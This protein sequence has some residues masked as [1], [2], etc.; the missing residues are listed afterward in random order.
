ML[1]TIRGWRRKL[2]LEA[3]TLVGIA[4]LGGLLWI[5]VALAED[6]LE[7]E[8]DGFDTAIIKGL[9]AADDLATP[10][11]PGWLQDA[12]SDITSLGS[13]TLIT[14]VTVIAVAYLAAANRWRLAALTGISITLGA[15]VE[16]LLKFGFGRPRPDI[17]PHLV[18]VHTLSF[19]SGHAMLSAMTYLTVGAVVASAQSRPR[20]RI[21]VFT[22]SLLLTLLIGASRVY[23]GVH[24]PSD[25]LA[26]WAAGAAW[27]LLFWF[28]ARRIR[29]G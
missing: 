20:L 5:F 3:S 22:T 24:W 27:A 6:V 8:Q 21:F 14:I 19:P 9:R 10:L 26:G 17:V 12:F 13:P 1:E 11:G 25:V 28:I 15:V 2:P 4:V 7:Q 23:L 16:K 18:D 29:D